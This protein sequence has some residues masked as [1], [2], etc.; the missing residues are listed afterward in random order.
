[1]DLRDLGLFP[2][3]ENASSH[4]PARRVSLIDLPPPFLCHW[5]AGRFCLNT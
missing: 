2:I 3:K 5:D 4:R 1:M